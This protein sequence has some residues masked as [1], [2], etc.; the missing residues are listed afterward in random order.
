MPRL[1]H[2]CRDA[3]KLCSADVPA[4]I[5]VAFWRFNQP[6]G[7]FSAGEVLFWEELS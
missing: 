1:G 2:A 5:R 7:C 6:R 3:R 4:I